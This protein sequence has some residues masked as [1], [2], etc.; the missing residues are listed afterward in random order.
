[1]I[2]SSARC[3]G[4]EER[5]LL[6]TSPD[7]IIPQHMQEAYGVNQISFG[8]VA[9]TGAGQTIAI[10]IDGSDPTAYSDLQY[11]DSYYGLSDPPSF[12]RYDAYGGTDYPANSTGIE[13]ALDV[14]WAHVMAPDAGIDLIECDGNALSQ[15]VE[16][17]A[18]LPDVSV[19]SLSIYVSEG[20]YGTSYDQYYTTPSGHGGVTFVAA[21]GDSG[22]DSGVTQ[23]PAD[24]PNVVA[25]GGTDLDQSGGTWVSETGDKGSGGGISSVES[26]PAYQAG[27]VNGTSSTQR[28]L[29]DVAMDMGTG[30]AVYD[31]T[32][33]SPSSGWSNLIGGTSLATPMFAGLVAVADQGRALAGLPALDGPGQTLPRLYNL[34][35][36]DF[37]DITSGNNTDGGS[38]G[39]SAG[40]GYDLVTG[41]GSP[42]A[43]KLVPDLAGVPTITGRV[44]VDTNNN[45]V[46]DGSDTPLSGQTVYLDLN[47]SGVQTS[48][49]PTATTNAS[50]VYTFTDE[51]A[52]GT[53]R[54][55]SP[56]ISGHVAVP[57]TTS[58][59]IT[60]GSTDTVN[61]AFFPT[62]FSTTAPTTNFTIQTDSTNSVEQILVNGSL[63]YS[64]TK[65]PLSTLSFSL[66]GAG[67]SFTVNGV[68]ANPIPT[69]GVTLTGATG[70]DA[71][72]ITGTANGNDAFAVTSGSITFNS[73][74]LSFSNVSLLSLTPGT[75]TDSLNV[76]SGSVTIPPPQAG[77]GIITRN[78]STLNIAGNA[79]FATAAAH[80]GR[81]LVETSALSVAGQLDLGG[82]DMIVHNGNLSAITG[83]IAGGYDNG[84]WNG[85]G[86][87][88]SAAAN[89]TTHLTALGVIQNNQS[90]SALFTSTNLFDGATPGAGDILVKYTYYGDANLDGKVDGSDYSLIDNGYLN[91]LT[92]WYNGDFNYDGVVDGSDY[93]LIDNAFNTQGAS[94]A[95]KAAVVV[96]SAARPAT[97]FSNTQ[98]SNPQSNWAVTPTGIASEIFAVRSDDA[99]LAWKFSR[100]RQ[101]I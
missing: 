72:N 2:L 54:L 19:V 93:T 89:N 7:G 30:V 41:L 56:T 50:G 99:L 61:F 97:V 100:H 11:F 47:D 21:T 33:N 77:A 22:A 62:S 25:V 8:G 78:F 29:P 65:S 84:Q 44:F 34:P 81:T 69:G 79:I 35:S 88:S 12:N 55:V 24:S 17:A 36:A 85:S 92:G 101:V 16:T 52:G 32:V 60:Y 90:G 82:N 96:D 9:G 98:V 66:T 27:K 91:H 70:G 3:E 6:A 43:N 49:D 18:S 95:A 87:E 10:V 31:T 45:G 1:M 80:S 57:T 38:V 42:I 23:F 14:E 83:M 63:S 13:Q 86:I 64:V 20:T 46:Y 73:N 37:H 48:N 58:T 94:L 28:T 71:L 39:Y 40:P 76:S 26:Q 4:L 75:G 68:N 59:A 74:P 5:R 15:G 67:D 53:V 51:P